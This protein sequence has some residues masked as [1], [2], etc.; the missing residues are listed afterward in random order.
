MVPLTRLWSE[1]NC[2]YL[3]MRNR[4]DRRT[5]ANGGGSLSIVM[6]KRMRALIDKVIIVLK[7][8]IALLELIRIIFP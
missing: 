2:L 8:V 6:E 7:A 3:T 5:G 1:G 4:R